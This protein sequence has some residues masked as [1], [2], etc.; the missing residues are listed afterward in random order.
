MN[1]ESKFDKSN[2]KKENRES[3][4]IT[5]ATQKYKVETEK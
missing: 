3:G 5:I 1:V 2:W 4:E